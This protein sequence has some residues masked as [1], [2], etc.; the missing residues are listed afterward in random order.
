[1]SQGVINSDSIAFL[2]VIYRQYLGN[3]LGLI[4]KNKGMMAVDK[5]PLNFFWKGKDW[6]Q[7]PKL[8]I[9]NKI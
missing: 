1:M 8:K 7:N 3:H 6:L 2:A 5:L 4:K 9:N